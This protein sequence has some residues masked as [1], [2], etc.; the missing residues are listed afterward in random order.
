MTTAVDR[1]A[2]GRLSVT[3]FDGLT[4][5]E[6]I[7]I[8]RGFHVQHL[9]WRVPLDRKLTAYAGNF[10]VTFQIGDG[11]SPAHLEREKILVIG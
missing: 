5:Q 1:L 4:I 10:G 7:G 2:D 11:P 3:S 8:L 9:V 6:A